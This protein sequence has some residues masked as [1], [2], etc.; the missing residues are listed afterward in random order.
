MAEDEA[1]AR[2]RSLLETPFGSCPA[3]LATENS[4]A[5]CLDAAA[6]SFLTSSD[7]AV[8]SAASRFHR[9]RLRPGTF[10]KMS[11]NSGLCSVCS[12]DLI[13]HFAPAL[14]SWTA[15][16]LALSLRLDF[17]DGDGERE[18]ERSQ[19]RWERHVSVQEN[20]AKCDAASAQFHHRWL[21]GRLQTAQRL[22]SGHQYKFDMVGAC[23]FSNCL[24]VE[25]GHLPWRCLR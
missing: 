16:L 8:I 17:R 4:Q 21:P 24:F 23:W 14:V 3:S 15:A 1:S 12:F 20:V 5:I 10:V 6:L 9:K 25:H 22:P 2:P 18:R 19:P 11:A 13:W 7:A